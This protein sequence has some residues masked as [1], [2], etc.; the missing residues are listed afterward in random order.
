MA[1]LR[2]IIRVTIV[3]AGAVLVPADSYPVPDIAEE[4]SSGCAW[5]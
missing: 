3:S 5:L 1:Q 4:R 2:S